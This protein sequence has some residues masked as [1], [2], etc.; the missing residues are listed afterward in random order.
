MRTWSRRPWQQDLGVKVGQD[1]ALLLPRRPRRIWYAAVT[2]LEVFA[3]TRN[4][5]G[6]ISIGF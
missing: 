4:L 5:L 2:A 3:V 1:A 6:G